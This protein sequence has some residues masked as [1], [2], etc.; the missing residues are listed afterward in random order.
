MSKLIAVYGTLKRKHGNH[1][2]MGNSEFLGE[3]LTDPKFTMLSTGGFPIVITKGDTPIKI[4]VFKVPDEQI[5]RINN[6]EGYLG[7]RGH[8]DNWYDTIDVETPYGLAE[9]FVMDE[10]PHNLPIV[11]SGE[12]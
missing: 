11:A 2:V 6:L 10:N 1:R 8:P 9:M 12:W 3:H 7:T 4:E 5:N